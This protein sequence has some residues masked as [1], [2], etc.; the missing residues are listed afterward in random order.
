MKGLRDEG[1]FNYAE[2]WDDRL[3]KTKQLPVRKGYFI[4]IKWK[5][6]VAISNFQEE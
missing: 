4:L 1:P 2:N 5:K 6:K 3:M